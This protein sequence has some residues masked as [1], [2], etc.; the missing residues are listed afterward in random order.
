MEWS[1]SGKSAMS[2]ETGLLAWV[3]PALRAKTRFSVRKRETILIRRATSL[4][5]PDAIIGATAVVLGANLVTRDADFLT[6]AY[7]ALHVQNALTM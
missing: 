2:G 5:L 1:T 4:K 7:S 6:C 3:C